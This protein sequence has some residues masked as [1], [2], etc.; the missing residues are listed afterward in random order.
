MNYE[1]H[2]VADIFPMMN[3][4]EYGRLKDDIAINGQL[5]PVIL[6]E[7][8]ILDGRNRYKALCDIGLVV[9]FEEYTG[10]QPITYV[11]SKNLHRRQLSVSQR[12]MIATT[13]KPMLEVEARKRQELTRFGGGGNI[14]TTAE[15]S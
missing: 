7:N 9:K 4:D 11:I 12:A 15:T 2:E 5:E 1:Y 10:D 13:V 14:S 6:Y 3:E 8:K